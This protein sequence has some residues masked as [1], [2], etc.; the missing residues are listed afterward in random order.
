MKKLKSGGSQ[1]LESVHN[2]NIR[3]DSTLERTVY[4]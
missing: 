1:P 4:V 2:K 3:G